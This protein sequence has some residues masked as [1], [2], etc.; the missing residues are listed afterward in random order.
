MNILDKQFRDAK[1]NYNYFFM[2]LIFSIFYVFFKFTCIL[3]LSSIFNYL[4]INIISLIYA[5]YS[6]Y[7]IYRLC[8]YYF[9]IIDDIKN[10]LG[11]NKYFFEIDFSLVNNNIFKG[12]MKY[13]K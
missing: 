13:G 2:R 12:M 5:I 10:T 9:N 3:F 6:L 8:S 11:Y 7:L 4:I 1:Y